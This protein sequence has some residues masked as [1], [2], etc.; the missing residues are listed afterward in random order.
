MSHKDYINNLIVNKKIYGLN[1]CVVYEKKEIEAYGFKSVVPN[2]EIATTDTLYDV[3][4][5]T[6]VLTV[7]PIICRLI[8]NKVIKFSTK[9]KSIL[10]NFKYNDI[11]ILDLLIHQSGL[12]SSI[13]MRNIRH[14]K[15]SFINEI[16]KLDK[17]YKTG[18]DVVYS[19]IGYI[20]LGIALEKIFDNYSLDTISRHVV[21][22][23]LNMY[24]TMFNPTDIN[25]CAPTEYK[26]DND[27]YQGEV[28]DWKGRLMDGVAGHAGVF[29]TSSDIGNF[30]QMVLDNGCYNNKQFISE[31]LI[32]M[33]FQTLTYEKKAD[34]YRSLCWITGYNKFI[35]SPRNTNTISFHGFAGPSISLDRDNHLGIC[36]M[37]NSVHPIRQNKNKMNKERPI[38]T[39]LIYDDYVGPQLRKYKSK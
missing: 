30:M 3:A 18:S 26:N 4:S 13:D 36:Q 10:P 33:W 12:P 19:D 25:R 17:S 16:Y 11:T 14:D 6:K 9:I 34:R 32:N 20:L 39:D 29:S 22:N 28:H 8:D 7:L 24:D 15:E 23:K 2:V 27:V 5:L 37:S 38:I 31:E 35:I 1:V 21:F